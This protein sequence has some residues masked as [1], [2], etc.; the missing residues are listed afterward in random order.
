MAGA[1]GVGI[2]VFMK[3]IKDT[4]I[5][6]FCLFYRPLVYR[7]EVPLV[8]LVVLNFSLIVPLIDP[9]YSRYQIWIEFA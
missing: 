1:V 8:P 5:S 7:K 2:G 9:L 6:R 4:S 3:S